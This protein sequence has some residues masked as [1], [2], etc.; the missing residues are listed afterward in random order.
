MTKLDLAIY[1]AGGA[2]AL[3]IAAVGP[4]GAHGGAGPLVYLGALGALV[5]GIR[6]A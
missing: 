4:E 3:A 5:W 6:R 2:C 1:L